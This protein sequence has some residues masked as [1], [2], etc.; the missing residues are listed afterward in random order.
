MPI[1]ARAFRSS[2]LILAA[3][4]I[5]FG[6]D[7]ASSDN[8]APGELKFSLMNDTVVLGRI[9]SPSVA[10]QTE[11]GLL[12]IPANRVLSI[13]PGLRSHPELQRIIHANI[14]RL[15]SSDG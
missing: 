7:K 9:A 11:F 2:L 14:Q 3:I 12:T 6:Q 5:F 8:S 1:D 10:V 13:T 4:F 15:T